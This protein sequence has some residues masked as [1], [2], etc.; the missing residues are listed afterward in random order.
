MLV[1]DNHDLR[2]LFRVG[3]EL[4]GFHVIM[5]ADGLEMI[6]ILQVQEIDAIVVDLAMPRIDG[7]SAIRTVRAMPQHRD[8]LIV[9]VTA[10]ADPDVKAHAFEAGAMELLA[11]PVSAD[12]IAQVL[13]RYLSEDSSVL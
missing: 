1:E 9:V 13:H 8:T 5:A 6:S 11:K 12:N 3:L 7:I 2:K 10:S 4:E